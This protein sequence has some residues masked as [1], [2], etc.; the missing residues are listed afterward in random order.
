MSILCYH[1]V[2]DGWD[3]PVSVETSDFDQQCAI[4]QRSTTVVPL[5]GVLDRLAAGSDSPSGTTVLTFDDGFADYAEHAVPIMERHG[6]TATMYIVAGSLEPG[7]IAVD[8][9]RGLDAADAPALM[10]PEQ[11]RELHD[12]GWDIGSH[13]MRHSDM[14]TLTEAEC[15]ADF[16]ESKQLLED[17][18]EAP[19]TT[20]A[21]PFGHH[22]PHVRRAAQQAGY[23]VA[24]ALPEGP[25]EA[26]PFSV[27]RTG[28]Y[29]GN[30]AWKFRVKNSEWYARVRTSSLYQRVAGRA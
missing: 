30:P 7:G 19:V 23:R 1:S 27:P 26:G 22:A 14:P 15:L 2:T 25:E 18:L 6:L 24:V 16:T 5:N 12:R 9:I 29:R 11:I 13:T 8:W 4:L 17:L 28:V 21:Y 10:S 3:D 20:L